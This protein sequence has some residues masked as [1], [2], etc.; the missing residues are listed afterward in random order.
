MLKKLSIRSCL[1]GLLAVTA[2]LLMVVGVSGVIA[3]QKEKASL[4]DIYRIQGKEINQ[5]HVANNNMLR[6]RAVTAVAFHELEI[7]HRDAAV[8]TTHRVVQYAQEAQRQLKLFVEA[9]TVTEQGR[10]L[11]EVVISSGNIYLEQGVLPTVEALKNQNVAE[12]YRILDGE[13]SHQATR[14]GNA[15]DAFSLFA[16]NSSEERL[17]KAAA[18]QRNMT[19]LISISCVLT[20]LLIVLAWFILRDRLLKPL[21]NA[22]NHLEA[23]SEGDLTQPLPQGGAAELER[24]NDALGVMQRSL[25]QSVGKVRDASLQIDVGTR[26]L[27][28]G[29]LNLSQRTE[30]SASSLE[31]TAASMEQLTAT[32]KQNAGNARHAHQLANSVSDSATRGSEV[33]NALIEKMS[34]IAHSSQRIGDILEVID[35]I[36]FQT[37]ILALNASVEAARAGEQGRG[38]AVV[39]NE[40]RNLAQRSAT[41]AKEIRT[42]IDDSQNRVSEGNSMTSKAAT[43]MNEISGEVMHVT[44][45]MKEISNASEEQS[46]GIEQVN[47]AV[48]QMDEVAQQNAS[49]V[50]QA[51]AA[52]QSL[53]QQSTELTS[54][55]AVFKIPGERFR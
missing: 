33:V 9:G 53:E 45:L 17:A 43:T 4:E 8:E 40:V 3:I 23:V 47:Q 2:L 52:T 20:L 16:N 5:L 39:A 54:A 14:F 19:L 35:G 46:N 50:E 7:G 48:A 37:N 49:L 11:A 15:V 44:S 13:I 28:A 12:Y 21:N 41:A 42:L 22:I 18:N 27:A 51:A 24:L 34:E 6:A 30:E 1:L 26:E 38:F 31:Q 10:K 29:N 25:Q 36:A 32:V 55:T